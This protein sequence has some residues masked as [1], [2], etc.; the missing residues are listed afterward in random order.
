MFK[1]YYC[2]KSYNDYLIPENSFIKNNY[3]DIKI[4]R[5]KMTIFMFEI[6]W[7][8]SDS[9]THT[10]TYPNGESEI[11]NNFDDYFILATIHD[12]KIK[13]KNIDNVQI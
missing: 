11:D 4:I 6:E 1:K 5:N 8:L 12:R 2:K 9:W 7:K 10:T 13:L 3:Y